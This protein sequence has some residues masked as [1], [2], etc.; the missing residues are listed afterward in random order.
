MKGKEK[1]NIRDKR[2]V[3]EEGGEGEEEERRLEK[4]NGSR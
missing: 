1:E 3:K 4:R 2:Y